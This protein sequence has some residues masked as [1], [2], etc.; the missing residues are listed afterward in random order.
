[1]KAPDTSS[2][3]EQGH[4]QSVLVLAQPVHTPSTKSNI[5]ASI[6]ISQW[7]WFK[8]LFGQQEGWVYILTLGKGTKLTSLPHPLNTDEKDGDSFLSSPDTNAFCGVALREEKVNTA[9]TD[10]PT[11]PTDLLWLDMDAKER[12]EAPDGEDLKHI[13]A[14]EVKTL[15]ASQYHAFMTKSRAQSLIPVAVLYSGHGLQAYFRAPRFLT[16]EETEA[17]NR[18]LVGRFTEFGAD[19]K[20]YNSGR[21][22]RV[23]NTYNVKNPERPLKT[24]LWH[25]SDDCLVEEL[26][27]ELINEGQSIKAPAVEEAAPEQSSKHPTQ[28]ERGLIDWY[29]NR[30]HTDQY[31]LGRGYRAE[32]DGRMSS[33]YTET[34]KDVLLLTNQKGVQCAYLSYK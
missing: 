21:V 19:P 33:P 4:D 8:L 29:N 1:M 18:A 16:K 25:E 13:P 26:V 31:L 5:P 14:D 11:K 24:E 17:A 2:I 30:H 12:H 9:N 7:N 3:G 20:V 32:G 10:P 22:L 28:Q 34:G 23:Q 27:A 15:V 6:E